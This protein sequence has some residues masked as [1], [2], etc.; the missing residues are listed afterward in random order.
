MAKAEDLKH[1][2]RIP[3]DNRDL[4][5]NKFFNQG[6]IKNSVAEDYHSHNTERLDVE[7]MKNLLLKLDFIKEDIK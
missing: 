3:S 2:Y 1:F 6:N 5:Y 4:N 7:G